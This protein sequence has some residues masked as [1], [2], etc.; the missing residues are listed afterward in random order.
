MWC[1]VWKNTPLFFERKVEM[2][3]KY[4][5]FDIGNVLVDFNFQILLDR[6]AEDSGRPV[7]PHSER[8]W[9]RYDA[10]ERGAI[11]DQEFVDYLND[12]KGLSW[13]VEKYTAVWCEMFSVN[14]EG[15]R[16]YL[17]A[18]ERKLPVYTLSNIAKHHVDAIERI[19]PGFL[20]DATGLFFSYQ[21][22]TRK[23]ETAIYEKALKTLGVDGEQCFFI[24]DMAEN[25]A[26]AREAGIHA[27]HFVSENHEQ[28]RSEVQQFFG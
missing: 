6:I 5:L 1:E 3:P 28:V 4:F 26:A 27:H 24:D 9:E 8:D 10:V 20:K 14:P 19:E 21:M 13:T 23:P 17:E 7:E 2:K 11:S 15:R 16:L 18:L 12:V 25:V 22:G